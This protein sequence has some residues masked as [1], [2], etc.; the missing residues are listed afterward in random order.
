MLE[1]GDA[2]IGDDH[3]A[4]DEGGRIGGEKHGDAADVAR[5]A[6]APQRGRLDTLMAPLLVF[7]EGAREFRPA[8]RTAD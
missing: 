1:D 4:G 8:F 6:E 2:A 3:L 5:L 7:P